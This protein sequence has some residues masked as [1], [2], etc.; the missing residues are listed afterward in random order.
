MAHQELQGWI[1]AEALTCA[2]AGAGRFTLRAPGGGFD[3]P[4]A[5]RDDLERVLATLAAARSR[6]RESSRDRRFEELAEWA[7]GLRACARLEAAVSACVGLT[8]DEART[9]LDA[10]LFR[11]EQ[12]LECWREGGEGP[13]IGR[14]VIVAHWSDGVGGLALRW[15]QARL[16]GD[17]A[18][19]IGDARF[20]PL[21]AAAFDVWRGLC[22]SDAGA[23]LLWDDG[24]SVARHLA[25]DSRVDGLRAAGTEPTLTALRGFARAGLALS[26]WPL[27]N[28]SLALDDAPAGDG[29]VT[30][31]VDAVVERSIGR[32]ATLS[33][34][35]P[36]QVARVIVPERR[37]AAFTQA[38]LER[39]EGLDPR[40]HLP[41]LEADAGLDLSEACQRALDAGACPIFGQSDGA[42][43]WVW[44]N[45]LA[46]HRVA[47]ERR[48]RPLLSLLR[49]R[50]AAAGRALA[51]ELDST[52]AFGLLRTSDG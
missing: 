40:T 1:G 24:P 41:A 26:L 18:V 2:N 25:A 4:R 33:G 15:A 14:R 28:R 6:A 16:C 46:T 5:G 8:P 13:A 50:D 49:A 42:R 35:A 7:R 21:I 47:R 9:W 27:R 23:A 44:T 30:A 34:Q 22:E 52:G 51:D 29:G 38:L 3:L 10:D 12:G 11:F 37:F 20:A 17:A 43:P 45:V 36:G 32:C 39:L 48:P 31:E 19:V